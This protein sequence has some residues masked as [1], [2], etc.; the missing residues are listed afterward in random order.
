[1]VVGHDKRA[2]VVRAAGST[3]T[4]GVVVIVAADDMVV[5]VVSD[6]FVTASGFGG[7]CRKTVGVALGASQHWSGHPSDLA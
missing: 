4:M 7:T 2:V 5:V 3:H 6:V 1:M